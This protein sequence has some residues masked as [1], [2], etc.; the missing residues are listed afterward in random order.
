MKPYQVTKLSAK[1]KFSCA[2]RGEKKQQ[3]KKKNKSIKIPTKNVKTIANP[4][5]KWYN[6]KY[7]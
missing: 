6:I 2:L 4:P 7:I 1:N 5:Q 3:K